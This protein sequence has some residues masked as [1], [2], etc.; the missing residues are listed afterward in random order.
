MALEWDVGF[1][2]TPSYTCMLDLSSHI[3]YSTT[4]CLHMVHQRPQ[5]VIMY[6]MGAPIFT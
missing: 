3:V 2:A 1:Y 4:H 5:M 6:A